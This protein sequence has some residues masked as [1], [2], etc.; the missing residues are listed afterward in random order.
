MPRT[1]GRPKAA[2][3]GLPEHPELPRPGQPSGYR[4]P[5]RTRRLMR[6]PREPTGQQG[7]AN[8]SALRAT[9]GEA[10]PTTLGKGR[11]A[12][13]V[14]CWLMSAP[15]HIHPLTVL[16]PEA[17]HASVG[18]DRVTGVGPVQ[19]QHWVCP[20]QGCVEEDYGTTAPR[21]DKHGDLMVAAK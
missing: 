14:N 1:L 7:D 6:A 13:D 12:E 11:P 3:A 9:Q 17:H 19:S 10:R 16:G 20:R 21:C 18:D 4:S 15:T 2:P 5:E 8:S